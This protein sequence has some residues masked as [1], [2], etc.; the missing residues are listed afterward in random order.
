M[1]EVKSLKVYIFLKDL[2]VKQLIIANGSQTKWKLKKR[3]KL[4][5][6][7][8]YFSQIEFKLTYLLK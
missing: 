2:N 3:K 4:I 7:R 8:W 5:K 1:Q 6:H